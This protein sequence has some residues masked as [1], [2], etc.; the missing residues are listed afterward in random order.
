[1]S[2]SFPQVDL[3]FAGRGQKKK[4]ASGPEGDTNHKNKIKITICNTAKDDSNRVNQVF[5]KSKRKNA[6][7]QVNY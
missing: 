7:T 2:P 4:I 3:K 6:R 5:R 1:M